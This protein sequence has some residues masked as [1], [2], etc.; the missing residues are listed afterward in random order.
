MVKTI[1]KE[2]ICGL[3]ITKSGSYFNTLKTFRKKESCTSLACFEA[4]LKSLAEPQHLA[5]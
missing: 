2:R 1:E 4:L 5:C 3:M